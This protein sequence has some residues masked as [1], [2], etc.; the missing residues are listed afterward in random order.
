[1]GFN[2]KQMKIL[3]VAETLF[4]NK[5]FDDTSVREIA[6]A[7]DVNVAMISYY[8]GS[9]EKLLEGIFV[10]RATDNIEKFESLFLDKKLQ[11]IEKV[12]KMIDFYIE[13]FQTQNNFYKIMMREQV[14]NQRGPIACLIQDFRKKN[15]LLIKQLI[16]EGQKT[17]EFNKSLDIPILLATLIG[18]VSHTIGTQHLYR[19]INNLQEMPDEQFQKHLKK[20]LGT[21]LKFFF[22]AILTHEI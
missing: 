8:F 2:E 9:K 20:K 16:Q 21:Y 7:A 5:G 15:Q 17:G 13:K 19:E 22:K 3:E 10:F 4:A 12:N 11:P 6:D 1:M 14:N 18:T